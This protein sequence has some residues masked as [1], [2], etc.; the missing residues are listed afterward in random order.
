MYTPLSFGRFPWMQYAQQEL[1]RGVRE[2]AG[3][4]HNPR[5]IDYLRAG[6]VDAGDETAWCSG[7]ANWCMQQA[8]IPGT[9]KS[10]ARS[11]LDWGGLCLANG[12]Y[13][14]VTILWRVRPNGWQGHVGFYVG[15]EGGNLLLL[16]GN[17]GDA[18]SIRPYPK[19]RLLG[20]RYP[21]NYIPDAS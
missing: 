2:V 11:W 17:Q 5:I 8:G 18:V 20:Y 3:A 19:S 16:G 12:V 13:G 21:L 14:A 9:G 15:A 4:R 10:N 1:E 7:F 6:G